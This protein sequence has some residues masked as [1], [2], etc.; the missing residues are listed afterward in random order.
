MRSTDT[1]RCQNDKKVNFI[2]SELLQVKRETREAFYENKKILTHS[3]ISSV[4]SLA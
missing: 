3:L 4:L 2:P 1:E